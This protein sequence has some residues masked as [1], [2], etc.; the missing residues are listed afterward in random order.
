MTEKN[1]L[2]PR[3]QPRHSRSRVTVE[4]ILQ[5]AAR[6]LEREGFARLTTNHVAEEAGV[7]IGS[8]Y[9]YFPNKEAICHALAERHFGEITHRYLDCLVDVIAEPPEVQVRALVKVGLQL[10]RENPGHASRLYAELAHFGG[11]DPVQETRR[12]IIAALTP[13]F[14]TLPPGK[15]PD[16]PEMVAFM[17][18][19]AN[20]QLIGEA[21]VYHPHWLNDN[22]LEEHL[23]MMV[24]GYYDR[25]GFL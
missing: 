3:K 25:L 18:T 8:L 7:S 23:C 12:Q 22:A 4:A 11:I 9:Q 10:T 20:S 2:K 14:E 5:A 1:Q 21:A 17:V 24:L 15:R 6:L 16:N 13:L 19:V